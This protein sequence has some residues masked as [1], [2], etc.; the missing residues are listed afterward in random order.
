MSHQNMVERKIMW[1]DL[2]S[3]GIVFYPRY[4]EWIDGCTHLFFESMG[5]NL[6]TLS[7]QRRI[8]FGLVETGCRYF[9]PGRYHQTIRIITGLFEM[10]QK[11]ITL[12]HRI[13]LQ[14][15]GT[16]LV[17]GREKRICMDTSD[18]ERIIAQDIPGD[19]RIILK[20]AM[21]D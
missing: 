11:T 20:K 3:L 4:Y 2:D 13:I 9:K 1:G 6:K 8:D 19:I 10:D 7:G 12:G 14:G 5:L 15:D 21:E 16:L 18:Q 17:E